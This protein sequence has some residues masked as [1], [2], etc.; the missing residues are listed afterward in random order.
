MDA[1]L[2]GDSHSQLHFNYIMELVPG[3][4]T[5]ARHSNPGWSAKS[6]LESDIL[7][8]LPRA[9]TAVIAL[10]GNNQELNES[11]DQKVADLL[12]RVRQ[13]GI[14]NI[15]WL[16]PFWSDPAKRADVLERHE[17]TNERL[18]QILPGNVAYIETMEISKNLPTTD[19]VHFSGA[20]YKEMI[21][22]L[23]PWLNSEISG[24]GKA[25]RFSRW[26]LLS[27]SL[28]ALGAATVLH[29]REQHG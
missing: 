7:D 5:L 6:Y 27:G 13:A 15:V 11:F 1:V 19:G 29:L 24:V 23:L 18:K 2:I 25:F 14:S 26:W 10:G 9:K 21:Q 16:G 20:R 22:R 4:N 8:S 28:F 3:L 12:K 17:W